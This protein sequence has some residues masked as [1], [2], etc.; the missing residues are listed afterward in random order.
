MARLGLKKFHGAIV[1]S[2]PN[3]KCL[4]NEISRKELVRSHDYPE[5]ESYP[6]EG[7]E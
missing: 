5:F 1:Q 7:L 6:V 3:D 2:S 4:S